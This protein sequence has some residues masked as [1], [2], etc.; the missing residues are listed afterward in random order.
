MCAVIKSAW[1]S[2]GIGSV[3]AS[4]GLAE[5]V[6]LGLTLHSGDQESKSSH[7]MGGVPSHSFPS[8]RRTA[9]SPTRSN[10]R[11]DM[12]LVKVVFQLGTWNLDSAAS[13]Q[14]LKRNRVFSPLYQP[15]PKTIDS[16]TIQCSDSDRPK[17]ISAKP[18][19]IVAQLGI[20]R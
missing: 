9:A 2:T 12:F 13:L 4:V 5:R 7:P 3:N 11:N 6:G 18:A 8:H 16:Q 17:I 19:Q 15:H 14:L 20:V 1:C 10:K